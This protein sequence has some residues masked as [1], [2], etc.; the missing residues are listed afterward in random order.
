[1]AIEQM[2]L[3]NIVG[4]LGLF[5]EVVRNCVVDSGFAPENVLEF[6]GS[7][8]EL[9]PFTMR[10]PSSSL[11]SRALSLLDKLTSNHVITILRQTNVMKALS[12][13]ILMNCQIVT[14]T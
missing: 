14:R 10:N 4:P 12:L 2:K 8:G 9:L 5:D 1:M 6:V 11:L 3:V 13:L 7:S